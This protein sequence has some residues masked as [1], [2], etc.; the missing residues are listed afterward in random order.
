MVILNHWVGGHV[1]MARVN[2]WSMIAGAGLG[3]ACAVT[4]AKRNQQIHESSKKR[5]SIQSLTTEFLQQ[6]EEQFI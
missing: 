3:A 4:L 2:W 1:K 5:S 6:Q